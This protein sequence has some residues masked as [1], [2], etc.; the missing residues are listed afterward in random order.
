MILTGVEKWLLRGA[1]HAT[2][3]YMTCYGLKKPRHS[4]SATVPRS[5]P[6]HSLTSPTVRTSPQNYLVVLVAIHPQQSLDLQVSHVGSVMHRVHG[7]TGR[8][9]RNRLPRVAE[10]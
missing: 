3:L 6:V 1:E 10:K 5:S 8:D 2:K 7:I 4:A 9:L